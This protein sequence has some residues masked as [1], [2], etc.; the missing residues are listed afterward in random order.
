MTK[1][2]IS[3]AIF[4]LFNITFSFSQKNNVKIQEFE[5]KNGL[6]VLLNEDH[7]LPIVIADI[8]YHVGSKNETPKINGFTHLFEHLMFEGSTNVSRGEFDKYIYSAG[9]DD[10]AFYK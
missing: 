9:G 3:V 5:L 2:I 7:S 8:C 4:I 10:N 1:I 6:K